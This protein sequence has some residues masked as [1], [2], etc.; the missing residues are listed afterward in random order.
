M[1][2][3]LTL[4]KKRGGPD[5][6]E[7]IGET[8]TVTD[9][10]L[11]TFRF[12]TREDRKASREFLLRSVQIGTEAKAWWKGELP[13]EALAAMRFDESLPVAV[14]LRVEASRRETPFTHVSNETQVTFVVRVDAPRPAKP[15]HVKFC[16][17]CRGTSIAVTGSVAIPCPI[18]QG[19][20]YP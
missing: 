2:Y 14:Y 3:T 8:E 1:I 9:G 17:A 4:K 18:C 5:D 10:R 6:R 15:E 13:L 20:R 7:W 19:G 11:R 16:R 12:A